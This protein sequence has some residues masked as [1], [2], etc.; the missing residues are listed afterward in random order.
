MLYSVLT[1]SLL[2][3][4]WME[5]KLQQLQACKLKALQQES[6]TGPVAPGIQNFL[7]LALVASC[8]GATPHP[9]THLDI[10]LILIGL[11][12]AFPTH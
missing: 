3:L 4:S 10:A 9:H 8:A 11:L 2:R 5:T 6:M 12:A 7:S 1:S